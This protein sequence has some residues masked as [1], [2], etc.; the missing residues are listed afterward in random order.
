MLLL[1]PVGVNFGLLPA[2]ERWRAE[3]RKRLVVGWAGGAAAW[4]SLSWVT[5]MIGSQTRVVDDPR[6][7]GGWLA[8]VD[9]DAGLVDGG[10]SDLR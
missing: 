8:G 1:V 5:Q 7:A 3:G 4:A 10:R 6:L 9:T 2:H